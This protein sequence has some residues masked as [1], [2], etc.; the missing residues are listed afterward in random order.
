MLDG[1]HLSPIPHQS[2]ILASLQGDL[3]RQVHDLQQNM[4]NVVREL[5]DVK[6]RLAVYQQ[7]TL[8]LADIAIKQQGAHRLRRVRRRSAPALARS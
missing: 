1:D 2:A 5:A 4:N 6:Q 3:L 8:M 7:A